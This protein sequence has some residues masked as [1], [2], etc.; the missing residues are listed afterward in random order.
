MKSLP[1]IQGLRALE[2]FA[3]HGSVSKAAEEMRLT[4]SA[5]SHQLRL[6]ERDLGFQ[7]FERFGPRIELTEHGRKYALDVRNA[8]NTIVGSAVRYSNS[9][10]SGRI[11]VSCPPGF[12][13]SWLCSHV[14]AFMDIHPD[15]E[16]SV[17]TPL[18]YDDVSNTSADLFI[19][20]GVGHWPNMRAELLVKSEFIPLCSPAV[21]SG[22]TSIKSPS[23]LKNVRFLH[24][25]NDIPYWDE[26]MTLA[27]LDPSISHSGV[28]FSDMN[29]A[30]SAAVAGQG[31][32]LG[33]EFLCRSA[34][35]NGLL[36][37]P[38]D[39]YLP[40]NESYYLVVSPARADSK[41]VTA[42]CDWLKAE[43]LENA[44]GSRASSG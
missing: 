37:S 41:A 38:F 35:A 18:W 36:I 21:F 20:F 32:F 24:M 15:I 23:D 25:I 19:A 22:N 4:S 42:F 11:T 39:L 26:W 17:T 7:L 30:Y 16:L 33:D 1:T 40:S 29:L 5:V 9:G 31:V 28:V 12:A 3:R 2:S 14:G 27:G 34:I 13:S 43:V 8:L 44:A 6:L 10:L